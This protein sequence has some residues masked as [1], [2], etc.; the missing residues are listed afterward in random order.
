[1]PGTSTKTGLMTTRAPNDLVS[2]IR[3]L[4]ERL[5]MPLSEVLVVLLR[6]GIERLAKSTPAREAGDRA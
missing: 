2:E 5:D 4:A 6:R 1:M 3:A